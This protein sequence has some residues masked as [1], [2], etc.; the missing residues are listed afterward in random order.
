[1]R[2]TKHPPSSLQP[3]EQGRGAKGGGAATATRGRLG[4]GGCGG[5]PPEAGWAAGAIGSAAAAAAWGRRRYRFCCC[6]CLGPPRPRTL[7]RILRIPV[8]GRSCPA[9]IC[10]EVDAS[11]L[12]ACPGP[13]P[14]G[15]RLGLLPLAPPDCWNGLV[16]L[17]DACGPRGAGEE[18]EHHV[19]GGRRQSTTSRPKRRRRRQRI[20]GAPSGLFGRPRG[21]QGTAGAC[22]RRLG[23][24]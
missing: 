12:A 14:P 20:R 11:M 10:S 23:S 1:M 24:W 2:A 21:A 13:G 6:C 3:E 17:R 22:C 5:Q 8:I 15:A 19:R 7:L 18:A 4:S 16:T 9:C